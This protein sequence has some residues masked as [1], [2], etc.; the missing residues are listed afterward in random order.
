MRGRFCKLIVAAT[1][2]GIVSLFDRSGVTRMVLNVTTWTAPA[3]GLLAGLYGV[4]VIQ[5]GLKGIEGPV[6]SRVWAPSAAEALMPVVFG[7]FAAAIAAVF[8]LRK[9]PAN[10]AL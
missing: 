1:M 5:A 3:L 2:L 7:F 6:D 10:P 4:M 9:P 8:L